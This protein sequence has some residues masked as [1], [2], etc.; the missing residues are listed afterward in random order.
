MDESNLVL[1]PYYQRKYFVKSFALKFLTYFEEEI[2]LNN[3]PIAVI[4]MIN[5][6]RQRREEKY[7]GTG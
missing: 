1:K 7:G 4:Q 5:T 2:F 3:F 6:E